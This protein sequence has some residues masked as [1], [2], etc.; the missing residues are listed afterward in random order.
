[1]TRPDLI[2]E[3]L[4]ANIKSGRVMFD[5]RKEV[6]EDPATVRKIQAKLPFLFQLAELESQRGGKIGMVRLSVN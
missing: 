2:F 3:N 6:F 1:M 4:F 5:I